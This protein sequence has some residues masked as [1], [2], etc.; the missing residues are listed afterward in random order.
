MGNQKFY[1]LVVRLYLYNFL[2]GI[3]F[4]GA[5]LVPFYEEWG[6]VK[7]STALEIQSW[8]SLCVILFEIPTGTIADRLGRRESQILGVFVTAVGAAVYG[9]YPHVVIFLTGELIFALGVSLISGADRAYL[10]DLLKQHELETQTLW[11]TLYRLIHLAGILVSALLGSLIA[12]YISIN[13][14]MYLTAIPFVTAGLILLSLPK[15][16]LKSEERLTNWQLFKVA[17]RQFRDNGQLLR[18]S[19]DAILVMSA[20]LYVIWLYQPVAEMLQISVEY[21]GILYAVLIISEIAVLT[22]AP[23]AAKR[24]GEI[25]YLRISAISTGVS[26]VLVMLCPNWTTLI[27]FVAI[28][29]GFGLTRFEIAQ[30]KINESLENESRAT[31]FSAISMINSA[32]RAFVLNPLIGHLSDVSPRLA[33]PVIALLCFATIFLK[34]NGSED[35]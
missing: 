12:E 10:Y 32:L 23:F 8:F 2:T 33:L 3:H 5:V 17:T 28:G 20:A 14:T 30:I 7:Y 22:T 25:R 35:K 4:Y 19:I 29:G 26:A 6:K 16:G 31:A 13:A 18:R 24:I 27:V 11:F 34:L 9:S 15:F 21:Y 1:P